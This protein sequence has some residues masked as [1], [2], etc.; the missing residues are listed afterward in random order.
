MDDWAA[1][2][3]LSLPLS[4]LKGSVL[5][6]DASHYIFH[7]LH[8]HSEP[9]LVALGGFPFALK[10]NIG[11]ELQTFK[12]LGITCVFVFNGLDFGSR[13]HQT[14]ARAESARAFE[15][16]WDLYDQQEADQVVSAF[17]S[18]GMV[19]GLAMF[20]RAANEDNDIGTP[21]PDSLYRFLQRILHENG[22]EF[23]VA[24]YSAAAQVRSSELTKRTVSVLTLRE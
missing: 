19:R 10:S 23:L 8:H 6:I 5:G 13:E 15:Q 18:A 17:S 22:V 1:S 12:N 9:L 3:T 21:E 2:H 24:P 20:L 4:S 7:H 14:H 11:R 16:A